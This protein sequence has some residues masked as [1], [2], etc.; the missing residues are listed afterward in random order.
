ML[1]FELSWEKE[2]GL[3]ASSESRYVPAFE[4]ENPSE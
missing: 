1:G 2:H 3:N 4:E